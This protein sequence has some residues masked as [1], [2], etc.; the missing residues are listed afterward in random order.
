MKNSFLAP[1]AEVPDSLLTRAQVA[2]WWALG[3]RTIDRMV[4]AGS[5]PYVK[6]GSGRNSPI[7]FRRAALEAA[8]Q[9]MEAVG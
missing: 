7:R 8:L 3:P 9:K 1:A 2:A 4:A 6:L 5:I